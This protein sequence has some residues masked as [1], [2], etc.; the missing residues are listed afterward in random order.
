MSLYAIYNVLFLD[1]NADPPLI[2]VDTLEIGQ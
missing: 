1:S 2:K